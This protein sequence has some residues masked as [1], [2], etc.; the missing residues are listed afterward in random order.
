V[1]NRQEARLW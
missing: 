1:N